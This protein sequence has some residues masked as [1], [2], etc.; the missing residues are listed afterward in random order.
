MA[1]QNDAG[2]LFAII[3]VTAPVVCTCTDAV[4]GD[5]DT[6]RL[7]VTIAVTAPVR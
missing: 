1:A 3:A 4:A 2:C 7:I 5:S 6:G